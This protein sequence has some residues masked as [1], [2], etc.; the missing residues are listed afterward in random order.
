[1]GEPH[2]VL[3]YVTIQ[4][5]LCSQLSV[6]YLWHIRG[7]YLPIPVVDSLLLLTHCGDISLVALQ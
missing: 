2:L 6:W 7:S 4:W 3:F 1:M 5:T